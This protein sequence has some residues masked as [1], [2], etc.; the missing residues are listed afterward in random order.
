MKKV[1][2]IE[3]LRQICTPEWSPERSGQMGRKFS[4]YIT[5]IFLYTPLSANQI[6]ILAVLIYIGGAYLFI[7][8]NPLLTLIAALAV[9]TAGVLDLVDGEVARYR[10][11][12][13][14]GGAFLDSITDMAM[15]PCLIIFL[16]FGV[17]Q[18][19]PQAAVIAL[20]CAVLAS[21]IVRNSPALHKDYVFR[22]AVTEGNVSKEE[23]PAPNT[24]LRGLIGYIVKLYAPSRQ[25]PRLLWRFLSHF[26][27]VNF[28]VI[29]AVIDFTI[30]LVFPTTIILFSAM[31]ALLALY[32]VIGI[33]DAVA[34]ITYI[35]QG[36][37][38]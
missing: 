7:F 28:V 32:A 19:F 22:V 37:D 31:Y 30:Y 16:T 8:G 9:R 33:L 21:F 13:G 3:E 35:I 14:P 26:H 15:P 4:I 2:P 25:L 29:A 27:F 17:Y 20:G 38:A 1:P 18:S 11:T 23:L 24:E 5:R 36:K 6:T 10:K 34:R 12:T